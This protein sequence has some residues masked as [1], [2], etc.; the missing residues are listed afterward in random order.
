[1]P[2][3]NN[4]NLPLPLVRSD[5]VLLETVGFPR[6]HQNNNVPHIGLVVFLVTNI[7]TFTLAT[8]IIEHHFRTIVDFF[9]SKSNT[10]FFNVHLISYVPKLALEALSNHLIDTNLM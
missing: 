8:N 4:A 3:N 7:V 1:M 5:K 2:N 10:Q 6:T 9:N